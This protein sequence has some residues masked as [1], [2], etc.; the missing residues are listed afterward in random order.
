MLSQENMHIDL[1]QWYFAEL[2]S[3]RQLRHPNL[4]QL[5][6]VIL[7]QTPQMIITELLNHGKNED[8]SLLLFV[9]TAF[10]LQELSLLFLLYTFQSHF[11]FTNSVFTCFLIHYY[12]WL[13]GFSSHPHFFFPSSSSSCLQSLM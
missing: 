7:N 2:F 4:V 13:C 10:F 12:Y 6:G 3:N 5:Y 8:C 11:T 1:M 9:T